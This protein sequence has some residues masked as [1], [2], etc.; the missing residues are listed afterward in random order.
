[1]DWS[2]LTASTMPS[3]LACGCS[4]ESFV[5]GAIHGLV[6]VRSSVW[7][8]VKITWSGCTVTYWTRGVIAPR[9]VTVPDPEL[10]GAVVDDL[11]ER[12]LVPLGQA[13]DLDG[14]DDV[15]AVAGGE[16]GGALEALE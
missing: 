15:L 16:H 10:V 13:G 3:A 1:M 14:Q 12:R 2:L 8:G 7:P 5:S 4:S 11:P 9:T 6:P